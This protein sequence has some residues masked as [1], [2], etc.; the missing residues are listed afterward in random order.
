VNPIDREIVIWFNGLAGNVSLIDDLMRIIATD[1]LMPM[2]F[3]LA[4]F[5][6]WFAGRTAKERVKFQHWTLIGISSI[7]LS[8]VTVVLIN[9]AWDRT[10]PYAVLDE[11]ELLFYRATDPSFPANPVAIGA[12]AGAAAWMAHRQFGYWLFAAALLYGVSRV[13]AGVFYP[14]DVLG[15]IVVGILTTWGT[16]YLHRFFQPV[17]GLF[18]RLTRGLALG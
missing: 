12:A 13:Y 6:M 14:T 7:G 8:N 16:T 2:V 3:S 5:G 15:G 4:M 1:Y 10:R 9:L 18:I 17:T 11:I